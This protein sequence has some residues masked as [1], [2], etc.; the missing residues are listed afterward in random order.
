MVGEHLRRLALQPV[1][2]PRLRHL[3]G[4][5]LAST[6]RA[7]GSSWN[8]VENLGNS[9]TFSLGAAQTENLVNHSTF[10]ISLLL[11]CAKV[12]VYYYNG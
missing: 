1:V 10:A 2:V 6:A 12:V 4:A 7:P 11:V 3:K 8:P 9:C 5:S